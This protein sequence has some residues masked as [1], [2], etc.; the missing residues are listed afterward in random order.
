MKAKRPGLTL[1]ALNGAFG[2]EVLGVDA[3]VPLDDD[4]A[5]A[6]RAA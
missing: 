6:L 4:T 2:I 3:S 1:R 5:R